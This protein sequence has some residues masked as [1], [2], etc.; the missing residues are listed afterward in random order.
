MLLEVAFVQAPQVHLGVA[1]QAVE[2][3][4][5]RLRRRVRVSDKR[6]GFAQAEVQV[7]EQPPH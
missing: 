4:I 6:A 7:M 3:F 1:R 5:S 2:F